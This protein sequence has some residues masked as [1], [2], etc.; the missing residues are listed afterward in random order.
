MACIYTKIKGEKR[1][2]MLSIILILVGV[3]FCIAAL[4]MG[5]AAAWSAAALCFF[6]ATMASL[7]IRK[8]K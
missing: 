4:F 5:H 1:V 2:R 8:D 7:R 3:V 6:A